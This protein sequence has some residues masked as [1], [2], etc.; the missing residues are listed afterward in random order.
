MAYKVKM[1]KLF[2]ICNDWLLQWEFPDGGGLVKSDY[3]VPLKEDDKFHL[4]LSEAFTG[5]SLLSFAYVHGM[6]QI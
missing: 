2:N 1:R 6:S 3:P 4:R 5:N